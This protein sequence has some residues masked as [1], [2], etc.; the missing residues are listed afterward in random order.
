MLHGR[1]TQP[2]LP[3]IHYISKFLLHPPVSC[4]PS[5]SAQTSYIRQCE[6]RSPSAA[7]AVR[8]I[9]QICV[10]FPPRSTCSDGSKQMQRP[11]LRC[12]SILTVGCSF[13]LQAAT[14]YALLH[15]SWKSVSLILAAAFLKSFGTYRASTGNENCEGACKALGDIERKALRGTRC[16][17]N[18]LGR[19]VISAIIK[20]SKGEHPLGAKLHHA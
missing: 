11:A 8:P 7:L 10:C 1:Q 9:N 15:Q 6:V 13:G 18:K 17:A 12:V 14:F 5:V 16:G 20:Y 19:L 3:F 2:L 4:C